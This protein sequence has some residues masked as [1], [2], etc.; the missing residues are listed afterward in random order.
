MPPEIQPNTTFLYA[1]VLSINKRLAVE[2]T[3]SD[4]ENL[5][6]LVF[7]SK[8][9]YIQYPIPQDLLWMGGRGKILSCLSHG[10]HEDLMTH[11]SVP[12]SQP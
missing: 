9:P 6:I 10:Y 5:G 3:P 4:Q 7:A 11:W 1:L 2:K 12:N 8:N